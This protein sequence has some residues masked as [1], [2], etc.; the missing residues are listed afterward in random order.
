MIRY[1]EEDFISAPFGRASSRGDAETSHS[2][3]APMVMRPP[4]AFSSAR[5]ALFKDDLLI[6]GRR[7]RV[8]IAHAPARQTAPSPTRVFAAHLPH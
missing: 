5:G 2:P 1:A 8:E 6:E 4:G 3:P 7:L